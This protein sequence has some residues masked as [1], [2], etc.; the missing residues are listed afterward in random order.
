MG[1]GD[2]EGLVYNFEDPSTNR[3]CLPISAAV[4]KPWGLGDYSGPRDIIDGD[5][6]DAID[7]TLLE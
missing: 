2:F 5:A 4:T 7:A 6:Q 1:L 3:D